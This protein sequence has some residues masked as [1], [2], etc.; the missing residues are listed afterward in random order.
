MPNASSF[1][2]V[3]IFLPTIIVWVIGVILSFQRRRAN[4]KRYGLLFTAFITLIIFF[5]VNYIVVIYALSAVETGQ[6]TLEA[7]STT[8]IILKVASAVVNFGAMLAI[9]V[10]IFSRSKKRA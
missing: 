1:I 3:L 9:I 10:A 5:L 8:N 4:K 2:E 6:L 7:L